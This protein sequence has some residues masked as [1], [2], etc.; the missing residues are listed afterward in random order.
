MAAILKNNTYMAKYFFVSLKYDYSNRKENIPR[1][2]KLDGK[3]LRC[4]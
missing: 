4:T 3:W 1:F 2:I